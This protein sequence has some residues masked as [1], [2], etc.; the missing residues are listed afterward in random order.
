M[1]GVIAWF[2]RN[3]VADNLL[4]V[5]LVAGGLLSAAS[6]LR[7]AREGTRIGGWLE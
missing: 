4:M 1:S 6:P 5:V 3:H 7:S 2:A